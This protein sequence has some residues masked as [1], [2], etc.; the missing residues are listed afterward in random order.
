VT[1]VSESWEGGPQDP[2]LPHLFHRLKLGGK[3]ESLA[4]TSY[5]TP[6]QGWSGSKL[7]PFMT[8]TPATIGT[9]SSAQALKFD[10]KESGYY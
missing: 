9:S 7:P 4:E 6:S 1:I 2:R 3:Y 5:G 8:T 10:P